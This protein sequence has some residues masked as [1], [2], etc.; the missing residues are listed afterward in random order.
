VEGAVNDHQRLND[1]QILASELL[2]ALLNDVNAKPASSATA[3]HAE[4]Q[5]PMITDLFA[6][7]RY[8]QGTALRPTQNSGWTLNA[9][10]T[11]WESP[12]VTDGG[13]EFGFAGNLLF[14]GY[15]IDKDSEPFATFSIDG[16]QAQPL[17]NSPNRLPLAEN[18]PSGEHRARIEFAGSKV[19]AGSNA[20]V[21]IWAVGAAGS[22][23]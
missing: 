17:K 2:I 8:A 9:D 15:D 18:L 22:V 10:G 23:E 3:S 4:L 20:K 1:E 14:V 5:A 16:G 13:S 12:A 11:K 19:P 6:N 7:C 21:K